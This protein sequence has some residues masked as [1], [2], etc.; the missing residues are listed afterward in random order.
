GT[1]LPLHP[2]LSV[3]AKPMAAALA[4]GVLTTVLFCLPPLLDVRHVR[5]IAVLRHTVD[6]SDAG[7]WLARQWE[8]KLQ[9]AS[10]MGRVAGLAGIATVLSDSWRVGVLAV[11]LALSWGHLRGLRAFLAL[12]RAGLPSAVRHGLANLHRPGNQSAAV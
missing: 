5:P 11:V 7:G 6:S 4:V 1:L 12:T 3:A 9:W 2:A 10:I 8:R